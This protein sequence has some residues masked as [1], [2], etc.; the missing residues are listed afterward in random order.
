MK[1]AHPSLEEALD[2]HPPIKLN[3]RTPNSREILDNKMSIECYRHAIM[4]TMFL[5]M[6]IHETSTLE[7]KKEDDINEHGSY[8]LSIPS[9]LCSHEKLTK[10]SCP[11]II[12]T[13]EIFNP[14]MLPVHKNFERVAVMLL[15]IINIVNLVV[16]WHD[17]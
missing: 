6:D 11:S 13:Q 1:M 8:S 2:R 17:S 16:C 14:F 7:L 12:I 3:P 15:F 10:L 4:E 5:R 9:N